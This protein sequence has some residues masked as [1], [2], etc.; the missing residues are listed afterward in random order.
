MLV[1]INEARIAAISIVLLG[2]VARAKTSENPITESA[3]NYEAGVSYVLPRATPGSFEW[4]VRT[5]VIYS[6]P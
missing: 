5:R 6:A 4:R 3:R 1:A 2:G